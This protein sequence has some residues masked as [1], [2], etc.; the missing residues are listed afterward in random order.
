MGFFGQIWN[1][2]NVCLFPFMI[3]CN[4]ISTTES[5]TKLFNAKIIPSMQKNEI[6]LLILQTYPTMIMNRVL[7]SHYHMF[8]Q[9]T[10]CGMV[11]LLW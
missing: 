1:F 6:V 9:E 8:Y 3:Y 7:D 2:C 11:N 10:M 4:D 5:A